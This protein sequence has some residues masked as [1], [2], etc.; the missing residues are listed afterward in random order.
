MIEFEKTI[1]KLRLFDSKGAEVNNYPVSIKYYNSYAR[2]WLDLY[3]TTVNKGTFYIEGDDE[4][5]MNK[6]SQFFDLL[7]TGEQVPIIVLPIG[8][9]IGGN[10]IVAARYFYT[11]TNGK[12]EYDLGTYFLAPANAIAAIS[13]NFQDFL[14]IA[15][16]FPFDTA[17]TG[18]GSENAPVPIQDLY[19][20][21]VSEI[22]TA[23]ETTKN[24]AFKLS[25]ISLKLKA[26]IHGTGE[27]MSASLLNLE[28]SGNANG[29]AIS[30]L[31]FDITPVHDRETTEA[32]MPDITGLTETAVRK[33]L[34]TLG[35]KLNPVYQNKPSVV[36]G[37]S[38]KQ[39]PVKGTAIHPNQLITVIFS[40]HE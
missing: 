1:I 24:S 14:P 6:E 32:T 25:N 8:T 18:G 29:E 34:K 2:S 37:D 40:K 30:E 26:F 3:D 31:V 10:P 7:S 38:F 13:E 12:I 22:A 17:S 39:S 27:S 33:I 11:L 9:G 5:P 4:N 35:L 16:M 15:S 19:S 21:I 36:N 28:N 20:H 23:A